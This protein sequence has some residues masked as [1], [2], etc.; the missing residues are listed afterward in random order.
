LGELLH[1]F[2]YF[3]WT[4]TAIGPISLRYFSIMRIAIISSTSDSRPRK[5]IGMLLGAKAGNVI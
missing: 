4:L 3:F 1:P 5:K 2:L